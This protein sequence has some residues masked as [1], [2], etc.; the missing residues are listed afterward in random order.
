MGFFSE[1]GDV[2]RVSTQTLPQ[3]ALTSE[4]LRGA[5][6]KMGTFRPYPGATQ[7]VAPTGGERAAFGQAESMIGKLGQPPQLTSSQ[8]TGVSKAKERM[9]GTQA[10]QSIAEI[11]QGGNASIISKILKTLNAGNAAGGR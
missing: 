5:I 1:G 8:A 9:G 2:R 6:G 10:E 7:R 4:V 11:I 3:Q